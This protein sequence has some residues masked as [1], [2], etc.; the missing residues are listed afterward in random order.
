M[1][2]RLFVL[3]LAISAMTIDL[4]AQDTP[5][6][7]AVTPEFEAEVRKF[8]EL[9]GSKETFATTI[10]QMVGQFKGLYAQVPSE[11]W[12]ELVKEMKHTSMTELV[13]M[14]IPVYQRHFSLKEIK[15]LNDFYQSPIGKKFAEK[16]PLVT[17]ESMM[18]GQQWGMKLGEKVAK[19]IAEKGY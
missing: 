18:I 15:Q 1:L 19:K 14:L 2:K 5:A 9:N 10:S 11:F 3:C 8:F 16:Q 4:S 12:D 6:P 17:Q 13:D 7:K